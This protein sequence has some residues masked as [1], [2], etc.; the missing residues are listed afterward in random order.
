MSKTIIINEDMLHSQVLKESI[1][2]DKLPDDIKT[3][4]EKN[5]TSLGLNPVFP[6]EYGDSFDTKLTVRRF[7]EAKNML[8]K[9][10]E[11][12]ECDD[13]VNAIPQLL[14]KCKKRE[15]LIKENLEK[16][17]YNYI[18]SFFNIPE[19]DV[20]ISEILITEDL[21]D[22]QMGV[23]FNSEDK[24]Y[25][26]RNVKH[27][28]SLNGEVKKRRVINALMTGCA[29]R[30]AANIKNYVA[31]IYDLDPKLP[32]LYRKL[33]ALNDYIL[34]TND[35]EI[36]ENN[37]S[38]LGIS[39]IVIGDSEIKS[40][41][42]IKG[43]VFPIVIYEGIRAFLEL[44]AAHGLP[45]S[46]EDANYVM[47]KADYLKAEPWDMRLG[48]AMWDSLMKCAGNIDSE[49]LPWFFM[50]VCKLPVN[51]FNKYMQE[52]LVETKKGKYLTLKLVDK[53]IDRME[54]NDF[55]ERLSAVNSDVAMINDNYIHP[56]E[57]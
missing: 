53:A 1:L 12:E 11:V 15:E 17:A 16:I 51:T 54:Y 49:V 30:V 6:E 27:R 33:L 34:F 18:V 7:E 44:I 37:P 40:S 4:L 20:N 8:K 3:T 55:E 57:L 14:E 32:D 19:N 29:M 36:D 13:M 10:G 38:Q 28:S 35:M 2:L 23:R 52:V 45:K 43:I 42:Q 26:F 50:M 31:E 46:K 9:I 24:D 22:F 39:K 5:K 25:E 48:P 47:Q 21:G 41:V 56:D